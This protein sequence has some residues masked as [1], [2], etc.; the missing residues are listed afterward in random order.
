MG[1]VRGHSGRDRPTSPANRGRDRSAS[2]ANPNAI[3]DHLANERTLLAWVRTCIAIMALG[4]VVARFGL[5]IRELAG[6]GH[7][8]SVRLSTGLGVALVLLGALLLLLATGRYR[9]AARGIDDN[10]YRQSPGLLLLLSA[11][12]VVVAVVLAGYL[13][14]TT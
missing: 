2:P 4:F 12:L 1:E 11:G 8:A 14:L 10:V 7:A 3:R 5:L 13:L 6:H 9:V